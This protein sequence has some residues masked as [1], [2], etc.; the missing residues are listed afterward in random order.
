MLLVTMVTPVFLNN[1]DA[2]GVFGPGTILR[3]IMYDRKYCNK[4]LL[5]LVTFL[6]LLKQGILL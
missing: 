5:E 1:N 6:C 3:R 4:K 2:E